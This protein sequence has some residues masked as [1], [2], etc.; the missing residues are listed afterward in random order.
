MKKVK[1]SLKAV[2]R[3]PSVF[4]HRTAGRLC[5]ALKCYFVRSVHR[6]VGLSN[7]LHKLVGKPPLD[8]PRYE[9]CSP[10]F[11]CLAADCRLNAKRAIKFAINTAKRHPALYGR[12]KGFLQRFPGLSNRIR[13]TYHQVPQAPQYAPQP[14]ASAGEGPALPKHLDTSYEETLF[15][16]LKALMQDRR[17]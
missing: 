9:E 2:V 15:L 4:L 14:E 6:H 10:L 13:R 12:V 11:A 1:N 5:P 7:L 16:Q 8:A 3:M 17:K